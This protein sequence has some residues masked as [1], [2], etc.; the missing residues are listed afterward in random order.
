MRSRALCFCPFFRLPASRGEAQGGR[1]A[2]PGERA[3][4]SPSLLRSESPTGKE[5]APRDGKQNGCVRRGWNARKGPGHIQVS[6]NPAFWVCVTRGGPCTPAL[7]LGRGQECAPRGA[8]NSLVNRTPNAS[9]TGDAWRQAQGGTRES[10]RKKIIWGKMRSQVRAVY[11]ARWTEAMEVSAERGLR[12]PGGGRYS[13]R[14][15]CSC[16]ADTQ[17]NFEKLYKVEIEGVINCFN[18]V[19]IRYTLVYKNSSRIQ[20][21]I[22]MWVENM[23][24]H[25]HPYA[26]SRKLII[27]SSTMKMTKI[28]NG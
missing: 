4:R 11:V 7:S 8:V 21:N 9:K 23:L 10:L 25:Q 16:F 20:N 22:R 26:T 17:L 12:E 15:N 2:F 6:K 14:S 3:S 1:A 18:S 5:R 28:F 27:H 13:V 19:F 24:K